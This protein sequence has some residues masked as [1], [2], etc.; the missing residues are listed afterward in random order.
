MDIVICENC[1]SPNT[2]TQCCTQCGVP[3]VLEGESKNVID[4]FVPTCLVHRYEGSDMLE[5][6][7]I[8]KEGKRY[9]H[10]ATRLMEYAHPTKV[11]KEKVFHFDPHLL[12][13]VN[14]LRQERREYIDELDARMAQVWSNLQ[15]L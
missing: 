9:Y 2:I 7:A 3:F 15:V 4:H 1:F 8:V 6:A 11:A 12:E 10:I 5:P 14:A 13:Q